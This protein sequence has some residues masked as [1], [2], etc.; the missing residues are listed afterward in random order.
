MLDVLPML[1]GAQQVSNLKKK[2]GGD[3]KV[4]PVLRGEGANS[5][6]PVI[7]PFCTPPSPSLLLMTGP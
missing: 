1:K 5:F 2:G 3:E 7:F 6:G 4:Y